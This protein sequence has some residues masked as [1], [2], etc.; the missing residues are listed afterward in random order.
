[1]QINLACVAVLIQIFM[2]RPAIQYQSFA[3]DDLHR[4]RAFQRVAPKIKNK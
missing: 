3:N 4:C 1:M 2:T